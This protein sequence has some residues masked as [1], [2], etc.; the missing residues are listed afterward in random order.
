[1]LDLMSGDHVTR[2]AVI[3]L[4]ENMKNYNLLTA[5]WKLLNI[6]LSY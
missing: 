1:M 3:F 4:R 2:Y 5:N 6:F